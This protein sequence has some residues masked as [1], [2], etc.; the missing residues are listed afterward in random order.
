MEKREKKKN[1]EQKKKLI[2]KSSLDYIKSSSTEPIPLLTGRRNFKPTSQGQEKSVPA[3]KKTTI[4]DVVSIPEK[5]AELTFR[6]KSV[7][8]IFT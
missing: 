7:L 8:D 2:V 1:E 4:V 6:L 5:S 3:T